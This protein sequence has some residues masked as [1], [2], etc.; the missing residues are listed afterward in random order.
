MTSDYKNE[1]KLV[2]QLSINPHKKKKKHTKTNFNYY[3]NQMGI[4]SFE[5]K[6]V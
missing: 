3:F 4:I 5:Y 1:K 6:V 2:L